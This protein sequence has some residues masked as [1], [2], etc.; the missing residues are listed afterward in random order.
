MTMLETDNHTKLSLGS[1]LNQIFSHLFQVI[2]VTCQV[3][4][5]HIII[6]LESVQFLKNH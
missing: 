6:S 5:C 1:L 2:Q 3:R 4:Q